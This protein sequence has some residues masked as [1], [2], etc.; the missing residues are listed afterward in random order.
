MKQVV[1]AVTERWAP[2]LCDVLCYCFLGEAAIIPKKVWHRMFLH[3]DPPKAR[4]TRIYKVS[5][6]HAQVLQ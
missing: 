3:K 4:I 1:G 2:E 5:L 6:T